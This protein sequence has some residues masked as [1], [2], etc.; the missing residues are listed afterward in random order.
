MQRLTYINS[1][2]KEVTFDNY[3]PYIFWVIQGVSNP[4]TTAVFTQSIGQHGYSLHDTLFDYRTVRLSCHVHGKDGVRQMY[5]KRKELNHVCN[6]VLGVGK[7]V[8]TNDYGSWQISA[9]NRSIEYGTKIREI[10]TLDVVFECPNPFW[11]SAVPTQ[12]RLAY[13]DGGLKFP[14]TTPNFFG[15]F[16]YRAII[17]NDSDANTPL[18]FYIDGG[19]LNP[20]IKN[21]TTGEFIKLSR[22]LNYWDKLY[23]NTDPE[24]MTVSLV[25]IDPETNEPI[26]SNAYGYLTDDSVLF[27]LVPGR[28][29]I[30]FKSEDE[31]RKVRIRILFH[32]LYSGV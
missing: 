6:P 11:Q 1:K 17:D 28:N 16:G 25:T 18:E 32:K 30:T 8:Y 19:S 3:P 14:V 23:I 21:E 12:V 31:N 13:V 26:K 27:K 5:E 22:H 7:L 4:A 20:I 15:T 9:F 2:G 29:I 10:Q 24:L